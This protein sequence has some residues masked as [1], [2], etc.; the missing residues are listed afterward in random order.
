MER[1]F[2]DNEIA[3]RV[4]FSQGD[5]SKKLCFFEGEPTVI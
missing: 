2:D 5:P 3:E 1:D 4:G